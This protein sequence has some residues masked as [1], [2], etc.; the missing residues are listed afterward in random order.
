MDFVDGIQRWLFWINVPLCGIALL[1]IPLTLKVPYKAPQILREL[2]E[3][4]WVGMVLFIASVTGL[5]IPIS[6]VSNSTKE[7]HHLKTSLTVCR[8]VSCTHGKVGESSYHFLSAL[9]ASSHSSFTKLWWPS[10]PSSVPLFSIIAQ[11]ISHTFLPSCM[12]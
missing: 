12:A 6:W 1:L 3:V 4:D 5:L 9:V 2:K 7:T 11:P 8:G 10:I